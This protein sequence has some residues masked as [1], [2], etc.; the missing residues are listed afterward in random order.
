MI[1]FAC[2]KFNLDEIIKCGLGLTKAELEIMKYFTSHYG[3]EFT[4]GELSKVLEMNITTLQRA[5]K[6][7]YEKKII[8]RHQKN[9]GSG[10][11]IYT[12]EASSKKEIREILKEI[13]K[14][15][16]KKVEDEIDK[17]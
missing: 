11:Y 9:L 1:D 12:Y 7:L 5:T 16:S 3:E 6:K 17:W 8:L 14:S 10:G 15:W 2:K 13:I 4:S